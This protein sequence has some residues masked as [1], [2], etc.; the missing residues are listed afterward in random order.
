MSERKVLNKYYPPDFDP[1]KLPRAKKRAK[2]ALEPVRF[3]L[4]MTV[5]C[6]SCRAFTYTGTKFNAKKETVQDETYRG[7]KIFR[8]HIKCM[9]CGQ[10]VTI[11]T[12]PENSDYVCDAGAKRVFEKIARRARQERLGGA[13]AEEGEEDELA[14]AGAASSRKKE[15]SKITPLESKVEQRAKQARLELEQIDELEELHSVSRLRDNTEKRLHSKVV[16]ANNEQPVP[17]QANSDNDE[18][19]DEEFRRAQEE[20]SVVPESRVQGK[21][22]REAMNARPTNEGGQNAV[23]AADTHPPPI[24]KSNTESDT[25]SKAEKIN[26]G[27]PVRSQSTAGA[28]T[29]LAA[30]ASSSSDETAPE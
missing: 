27:E 28:L 26:M 19:D 18:L 23:D 14:A 5:R 4:P 6:D 3:M 29:A 12:D 1:S 15:W 17:R 21:R 16:V 8:F 9:T 2:G 30:Y 7:I 13:D 11:K 25:T 24:L 22:S 20:I 10:K